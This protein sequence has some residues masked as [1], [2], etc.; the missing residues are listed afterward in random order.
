MITKVLC[1]DSAGQH[2]EVI[3][4]GQTTL[5]AAQQR[6]IA[7]GYDYKAIE[8]DSRRVVYIESEAKYLVKDKSGRGG[9]YECSKEELISD[10]DEDEQ[11]SDWCECAEVGD[12]FTEMNNELITRIN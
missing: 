6:I 11:L 12:S 7:A 5:E 8:I 2:I 1:Q 4:E 10:H 3:I 9:T